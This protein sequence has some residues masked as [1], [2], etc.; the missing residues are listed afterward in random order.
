MNILEIPATKNSGQRS[1]DISDAYLARFVPYFGSLT[2]FDGNTWRGVVAA[3]PVAGLCRDTL[4]S[5]AL[6]LDWKVTVRD[7]SMQDELAATIKYYNNLLEKGNGSGVDYSTHVEWIGKDLLDTPF[8]GIS[9]VGRDGDKPN[10]RVRWVEP[11]DAATCYPTMN[12]EFPVIQMY[13]GNQVAFPVHGMARTMM[14]PRTRIEYKG[15]GIAP[16][17]VVYQALIM[18]SRGDV[19]YANLLLDIPTSGILDLGDMEKDSALEWV[20]AYKGLLANGGASSS[21][22]IPVLYEHNNDIKFVPFGKVPNDIMFDRITERYAALVSAAYGMSLSDIGL[23]GSASGETLAGSIRSERKTRKTGFA[24]LKKKLKYY[25]EQILP[26]SLQFNWVD[27][28]D[29]VN[30]ALGRARLANASAF[31]M[32]QEGGFISEDEGRQQLIADGMFTISMPEAAPKKVLPKVVKPIN[33][34]PD[35]GN[36]MGHAVPV[37]AGGQGEVRKYVLKPDLLKV[38]AVVSQIL[39]N[40]FAEFIETKSTVGI[41]DL[42]LVRIDVGRSILDGGMDE[43]LHGVNSDWF[44]FI[45]TPTAEMVTS[46][47]TILKRSI[48]MTLKDVLLADDGI[49]FNE[50]GVYDTLLD[51]VSTRLSDEFEGIVATGVEFIKGDNNGK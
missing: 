12:K 13:A 28:D 46:C 39:E 11:I 7:S 30:V 51:A 3:Q 35:T 9:E 5:S 20:E 23:Q 27:Y 21:F 14:N 33:P 41:D 17:E 45:E 31:K 25:F 1:L 29:E 6:S 16:P 15:W 40:S 10:G 43:Y 34:T 42:P 38:K 36:V 26:T 2:T 19:Y 4:I 44:D 32:L 50:L 24:R 8:G 37:S 49:D 47:D 18:L 48:L 22:K